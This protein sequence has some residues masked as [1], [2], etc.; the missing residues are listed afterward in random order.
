MEIFDPQTVPTL[1][2][3]EIDASQQALSNDVLGNAQSRTN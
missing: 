1:K 2:F 3:R